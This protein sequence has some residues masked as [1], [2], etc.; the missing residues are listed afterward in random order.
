MFEYWY[1]SNT[2]FIVMNTNLYELLLYLRYTIL[3]KITNCTR[4]LY[5]YIIKPDLFHKKKKI[6]KYVIRRRVMMKMI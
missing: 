1:S 3:L 2:F 6:I 4:D 5:R